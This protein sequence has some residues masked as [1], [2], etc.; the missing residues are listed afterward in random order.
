MYF[1]KGT[2]KHVIYMVKKITDFNML[3]NYNTKTG[4]SQSNYKKGSIF[5]NRL[6]KS[7]EKGK[8]TETL[9]AHPSSG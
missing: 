3:E 1:L 7:I 2:V 6:T 5:D 8:G 4:I 9:G